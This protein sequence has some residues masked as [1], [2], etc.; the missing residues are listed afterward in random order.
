MK[1]INKWCKIFGFISINIL[2]VCGLSVEEILLI[3][4]CNFNKIFEFYLSIFIMQFMGNER[5]NITNSDNYNSS[6]ST[7]HN[8]LIS[9]NSNKDNSTKFLLDQNHKND[10]DS[11]D[12]SDSN[13]SSDKLFKKEFQ[14][15]EFQKLDF[16]NFSDFNKDF[17]LED[18]YLYL[19]IKFYNKGIDHNIPFLDWFVNLLNNTDGT[20][21]NIDNIIEKN[22]NHIVKIE[23]ETQLNNL[24]FFRN[25]P[26]LINKF[27]NSPI[28]YPNIIPVFKGLKD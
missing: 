6:T 7:S 2:K 3:C 24:A 17:N 25:K 12:S 5:Q 27:D 28:A 8:S 1:V 21:S 4:N 14:K 22:L 20:K 13:E 18:K 10:S 23:R 26:F 16:V 19:K 15:K 9:S 11:S